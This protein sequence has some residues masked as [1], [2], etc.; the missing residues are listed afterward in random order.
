MGQKLFGTS[1]I[2]GGIDSK[3]TVDLALGLG[4]ALGSLLKGRGTVGV[5]ID[6]RTS[7]EMLRGAFVS[8]LLSTGVDVIDLGIA[9]MPTVAYH[10]SI[11]GVSASVIITASHNPPTDNGFKFFLSGR[12]FIQSEEEFLEAR[13][14]DHKFIKADWQT[15][16]KV[17]CLDIRRQYLDR[18]RDF[19]LS[20]GGRSKGTKI[21][22]DA[23]NG[24]ATNYTPHLLR[25][26]GFSVTT[27][28]AHQDGHF[29]GRPAEPSPKNLKDTMKMTAD[30]DFSV[31]LC[32]DGDGDRLAVIDEDGKF[33]DQN[34]VIALFARDEVGRKGRGTVVV[35]I[36]TSSVI[37][38]VVRAEGGEV[39]RAPLGSLQEILATRTD[40]SIVFASEPWKPIFVELGWW[41]DGVTGAARFAQ[42]MDEM[43]DGSC[44]KLMKSIPEYPILRDHIP[45]PDEIKPRFLP[46]VKEMLVPEISDI[47]QILEEDGIRIERKD[48]SYVL[49]RV[50]GTEPKARVYIG[51]KNQATLDKLANLSMDI[52]KRAAEAASK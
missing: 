29:P 19:V 52:M 51:A 28:N 40:G 33:I 12:E 35:S 23:A 41:M 32:H 44:I 47:E 4:R 48:G 27:V 8:G 10:S 20:R 3:V 50:S 46:M 49:V 16:G 38:E 14:S 5:G 42:M 13:V 24:A 15:I 22:V 17:R 34:R 37:D 30:S 36:D 18:V 11:T 6:A 43:G 2:R 31:A 25:E 45:C 7:R 21:L 9:P 26:L 1:G 39:V